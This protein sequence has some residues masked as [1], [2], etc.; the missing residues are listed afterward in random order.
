MAA[1]RGGRGSVRW[2]VATKGRRRGGTG[3][4]DDRTGRK[5][6]R[7]GPARCHGNGY[8]GIFGACDSEGGGGGQRVTRRGAVGGAVAEP[9]GDDPD[10]RAV[11]QPRLPRLLPLPLPRPRPLTPRP[12][13]HRHSGRPQARGVYLRVWAGWASVA[14][15]RRSVRLSE[16]RRRDTG[17]VM[18]KRARDQ[19]I[20]LFKFLLTRN[21][22]F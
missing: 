4:R 20:W 5:G 14:R 17:H 15:P 19:V 22:Q 16:S 12:A 2:S 11:E 1:Q 9:A 3:A 10:P 6:G 21:R 7:Q 8:G 18:S 13:P